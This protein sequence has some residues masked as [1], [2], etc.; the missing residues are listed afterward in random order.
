MYT[1]HVSLVLKA[2]VYCMVLALAIC[3]LAACLGFV[4]ADKIAFLPV[5]DICKTLC[6]ISTVLLVI[7]CIC[8]GLVVVCQIARIYEWL[9]YMALS[10]LAICCY[11]AAWLTTPELFE[12]TKNFIGI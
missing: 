6:T 12:L 7:H 10:L 9:G 3:S 8:F 4:F 5:V 1:S 2:F 11:I